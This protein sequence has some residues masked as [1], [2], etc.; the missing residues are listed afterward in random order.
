M[1]NEVLGICEW[2]NKLR[3]LHY[4]DGMMICKECSK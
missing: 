4:K 1:I 3:Y 2:C